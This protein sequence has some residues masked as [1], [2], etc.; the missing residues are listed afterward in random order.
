MTQSPTYRTGVA[1]LGVAARDAATGLRSAR[2]VQ[3]TVI[4]PGRG[5]LRP[6]A[7]AAY[8]RTLPAY[9]DLLWTLTLHRLRVRYRQS[10]L[11][12]AWAVLQP[13]LLMLIFTVLFALTAPRMPSAGLPYPVFVYAAVLPWTF[14]STA[15][16]NGTGSLVGHAQLVTKV[17][18]PR[19]WLPLSYLLAA[20]FDFAVASLLLVGLMLYH[21][22]A[23]TWWALWSVPIV[24]LLGTLAL[25]LSLALGALQVRFRDIGLAMPLLL[26]VWM[27][28]SPVV[29]P[30]DRV[31]ERLR[32]VYEL[33]PMV[34]LI[35]SFRRVTVLGQP[36]SWDALLISV[37]EVTVVLPACYLYFRVVDATVA[38]RL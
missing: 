4:R 10:L 16:T 13:L 21:G 32:W 26:Q 1:A 22:V 23:P 27:F 14:F 18:F 7:L 19:E 30:L 2:R 29:Y 17:W 15:L 24:T 3:E 8:L 33:N 31:P 5:R 38:D 34:G 6:A 9:A 37:L 25:A 28:L 35:D 20:L 11:G 12:W 36:P